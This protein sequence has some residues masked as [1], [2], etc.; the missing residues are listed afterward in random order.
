MTTGLGLRIR[1]RVAGDALF[2]DPDS[3]HTSL[4][5]AAG[6]SNGAM[7][8][9][10]SAAKS[11]VEEF[12]IG[13]G[14]CGDDTD[15][16][17]NAAVILKSCVTAREESD[18]SSRMTN[19]KERAVFAAAVRR[20]NRHGVGTLRHI[21]ITT[22]AMYHF[23]PFAYEQYRR[24]VPIEC[25]RALSADTESF[26]CTVV[27]SDGYPSYVLDPFTEFARDRLMSVLRTQVRLN[28]EC[29]CSVLF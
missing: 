9:A 1:R 27:C 24:R 15:G 25:V 7:L 5:P 21:L 18:V 6:P 4:F 8:H 29:G 23:Y 19:D 12:M 14:A 20:I 13:N 11:R 16:H 10:L 28:C 17:L 3:T 22:R 2:S 26:Q